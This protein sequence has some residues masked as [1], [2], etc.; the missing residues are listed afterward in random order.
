MRQRGTATRSPPHQARIS[1]LKN[2]RQT[3]TRAALSRAYTAVLWLWLTHRPVRL[4]RGK[5]I[6]WSWF[7]GFESVD[8]VSRHG[9]SGLIDLSHHHFSVGWFIMD[10]ALFCLATYHTRARSNNS[11][12]RHGFTREGIRLLLP[13]FSASRRSCPLFHVELGMV[14]SPC[15]SHVHTTP[16]L[17]ALH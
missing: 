14:F 1:I 4:E 17:L 15:L 5:V 13:R 11:R 16:S 9:V 2:M 6:P 12:R 8:R 7:T 10:Q 3:H